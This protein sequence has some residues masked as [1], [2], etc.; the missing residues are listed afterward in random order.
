MDM[1]IPHGFFHLWHSYMQSQ[2]IEPLHFAE[3]F[4]L[5]QQLNHILQAPISQQTSYA[6]FQQLIELTYS[7]LN[8]PLL[9]FEMARLVKA[10]H[11][12]VLGYMATRS[13]SIAESL[14]YILRFSRLVID[15]EQITP[16]QMSFDQDDLILSWPFLHEQY[17]LINELNC[18]FIIEMARQLLPN[19]QFPLKKI[20]FAHSPLIAAYHYQKFYDCDVEFNSLRYEFVIA[21]GSLDLKLTQADPSLMQ[22][23]I[24]QAEEA[25]AS[26][27][28]NEDLR[29]KMQFIIAEYLKLKQQAPK[30]E[31]IAQELYMSVRT[32]QRQ[33]K[34]HQTSFKVLL[35]QERIKQCHV[36]IAKQISLTEIA[37]MLGYSDQ[38][39]LARAYKAATGQT[40][41][42]YRQQLISSTT[43]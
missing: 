1:Q 36:L 27:Q 26:K 32:L 39:A 29:S 21:V 40:L 2:A 12:G 25:I 15:G 33:L 24:K 30:I 35:E 8:R 19:Q 43:Q 34:A 4:G 6:L 37:L 41:L 18:A 13:Q 23:L 7:E 5:K 31:D 22:L 42:Q 20:R 10:E 14:Q 11:F 3:Q 16:M 38:S 17:C 28:Q 9:V